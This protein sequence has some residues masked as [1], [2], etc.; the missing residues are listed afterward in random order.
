[1]PYRFIEHTADIAVEVS[2]NTLEELFTI[3]CHAWRDTALDSVDTSSTDEQIICVKA[4]SCEALLIKFLS[5]LNFLL[6]TK[7]WVFN[8]IS[9][10]EIKKENSSL[11]LNSEILGENYDETIHYLKEEI[12]AVTF[13]QMKIEKHED[14]F[15]TLIVFD[16]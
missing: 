6:Y 2:A 5:E 3:S 10:L 15:K 11:I 13:H 1:M 16:I 14:I 12:K 8:S 7:K 9:R 4:E